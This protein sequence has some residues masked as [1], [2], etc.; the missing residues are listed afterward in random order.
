MHPV[1]KKRG[2]NQGVCS[3]IFSTEV[4]K[5]VKKLPSGW[6]SRL[7][8]ICLEFFKALDVVGLS[9][10]TLQ[11]RVDIGG[12][13]LFKKG[14]QWVC[15]NYWGTHCSASL[16]R[17]IQGYWRNLRP[18]FS[19]RKRWSAFPRS[20]RRSCL[21]WRSTSTSGSC[22][23]LWKECGGRST[24]PFG[25]ASAVMRTLHHSI[26][27]KRELSEKAKLSIF[28]SIFVPILTYGH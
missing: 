22:S 7:D 24:R 16:V 5:M 8:E 12:S 25:A 6:T 1:V 2:G 10:L 4:V 13:T 21:K 14:D 20:G 18:W 28:K 15:S 23:W 19:A 11:H 27:V 17:S 3:R 9:W 26:L